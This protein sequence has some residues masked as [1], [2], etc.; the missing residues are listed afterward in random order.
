MPLSPEGQHAV[1][2]QRWWPHAH[3]LTDFQTGPTLAY[4]SSAGQP[5]EPNLI[6]W[7]VGWAKGSEWTLVQK[8]GIS[9]YGSLGRSPSL[10]A[11][12]ISLWWYRGGAPTFLFHSDSCLLRPCGLETRSSIRLL[13]HRAAPGCF[14]PG[15]IS[16]TLA[17]SRAW[18]NG[19]GLGRQ[20][21]FTAHQNP[22]CTWWPHPSFYCS[23][24]LP[25]LAKG[26]NPC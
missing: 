23:V 6:L 20:T 16:W 21:S 3:C 2:G 5:Q 19:K 7:A 18:A 11:H 14:L 8:T 15:R 17:E 9:S 4:P 10:P 13:R 26:W 24:L 1:P 25:Q 12:P 22:I